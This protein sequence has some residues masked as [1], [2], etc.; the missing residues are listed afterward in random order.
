MDEPYLLSAA[1]Y[2]ELNPVRAGMVKAAWDY[3][4]SSVHAHLVR[5]SDGYVEVAPLL[6]LVRDWKGFLQGALNQPVKEFEVHERTGRP[7]GSESFIE[8]ASRILGRDLKPKKP[9]PKPISN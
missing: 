9:G 3:P 7:L 1:A 5:E 8:K 2:V 6:K 4:W